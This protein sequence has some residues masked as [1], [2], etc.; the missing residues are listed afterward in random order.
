MD[1]QAT[2]HGAVRFAR[3]LQERSPHEQRLR[4]VYVGSTATIER[5]LPGPGLPGERACTMMRATAE[6]LGAAS[7]FSAFEAVPSDEPEAVLARVA[8][9]HGAH[10]LVIG[11]AGAAGEWSL[12]SLGRV[13]RRLL[14]HVPR[15]VVVV[16]PDLDLAALG[17]GPVVIGVAPVDH[18][19]TAIQFGRALA[20]T[21]DLPMLL[22]H[23]IPDPATF[24]VVSPDPMVPMAPYTSAEQASSLVDRARVR[25]GAEH[26]LREWLREHGLGDP[27]L[28]AE[29]GRKAWTLLDVARSVQASM[30]VCGSRRLSL[31]ERVFESSVGTELAARADRPVVVVPPNS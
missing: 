11:R 20:E 29:A 15:P 18:A 19:I 21:L 17:H 22:V 28:R 31:V 10:G 8:E 1:L 4:G 30:I 23:V 12:V 2:S 27:P 5:E 7:A 6:S 3:W 24:P 26:A 9:E 16:P 14:R 25:M 13:A